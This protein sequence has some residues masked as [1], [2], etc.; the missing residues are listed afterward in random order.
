MIEAAGLAFP[1]APL[2]AALARLA[3]GAV[4]D[5]LVVAAPAA[6]R[7]RLSVLGAS[8]DLE[9]GLLLEVGERVR[10][11]VKSSEPLTLEIRPAAR[12]TAEPAAP[13]RPLAPDVEAAVRAFAG[14]DAARE[15]AARFLASRGLGLDPAAARGLAALL[16]R[17]VAAGEEAPAGAAAMLERVLAAIKSPGAPLQ[18]AADAAFARALPE[19]AARAEFADLSGPAPARAAAA[20]KAAPELREAVSLL[21]AGRSLSEAARAIQV[22]NADAASR[23]E[24]V[25]YFAFG[26]IRDGRPEGG[27]GRVE[28]RTGGAADPAAPSRV[29]VT[30]ELTRLGLL[31]VAVALAAGVASV[32]V[33][34]SPASRRL[35]ERGRHGLLEALLRLGLRPELR[36]S[37]GPLE[38]ILPRPEGGLDLR[39]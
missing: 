29:I 32:T 19:L 36:F 9:T 33:A 28:A 8:L 27:F 37:D 21:E 34:A 12:E 7:F 16:R 11:A 39:A 10:L 24:G 22:L 15:E 25:A 38:P 14:G 30:L 26:W 2:D 5:A 1:R 23:A 6:G 3:V 4:F 35:L 20:L 31:Q 17:T 18:A 13:G